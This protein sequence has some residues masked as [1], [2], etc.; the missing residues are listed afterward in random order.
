MA[1]QPCFINA[2]CARSLFCRHNLH[3]RGFILQRKSQN[4]L[5]AFHRMDV[6]IG[7][8]VIR[9]L[10]RSR[11]F[12]SGI[13][14]VFYR[15]GVPPAVFFQT[16]DWQ[17]LTT[18]GDLAGHRHVGANRVTGKTR[19]QRGTHGNTRTWTIFR[20]RSFRYV[21]V[22]VAFF[23]KSGLIPSFSARAYHG[24]RSLNRFLHDFTQRTGVGQLTFTRYAGGFD[25]QQIAAHFRPRQP[26]YLTNAVSLSA[27]P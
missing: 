20:R 3:S 8:Y 4:F 24:Q 23:V 19:N 9:N 6:Q 15:H 22:D 1:C 18:Q 17:N 27:R 5:N 10:F 25:G 16:T 14:T 12:S 21:N 11:L 7:N 26:G 2:L 13:K